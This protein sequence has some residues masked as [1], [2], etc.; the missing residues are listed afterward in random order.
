M[1]EG[2]DVRTSRAHVQNI[3]S[4]Q[5]G[6]FCLW[7]YNWCEMNKD[8]GVYALVNVVT[9]EMYVGSSYDIFSRAE[10]HFHQLEDRKHHNYWLQQSYNKNPDKFSF[11]VLEK[12]PVEMIRQREQKWINRMMPHLLNIQLKVTV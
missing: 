7:R 12:V 4:S 9:G 3:L 10:Q 1:Q 11:V 8:S 6:Y 5:I 2:K